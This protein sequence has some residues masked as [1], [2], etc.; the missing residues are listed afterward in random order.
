MSYPQFRYHRT[1]VVVWGGVTG[2][3]DLRLQATYSS[4]RS[5]PIAYP[6]TRTAT[7]D[8]VSCLQTFPFTQPPLFCLYHLYPSKHGHLM[9]III[10][11]AFLKAKDY[12]LTPNKQLQHQFIVPVLTHGLEEHLMVPLLSPF[13]IT[14]LYLNLLIL[15]VIITGYNV[16]LMDRKFRKHFTKL[17]KKKQ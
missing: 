9:R 12:I 6:A 5:E 3:I 11:K 8:S 4:N 14:T 15:L 17:L 2:D 1:N 13:F 16:K 10:L 7:P